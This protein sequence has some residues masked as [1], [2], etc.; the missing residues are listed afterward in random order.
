METFKKISIAVLIVVYVICAVLDFW[1]LY[2]LMFGP[3]KE[4]VNTFH[5]GT[6]TTNP[7]E[8]GETRTEYVIK[9]KYSSNDNKNGLECLDIQFSGFVDERSEEI[10]S[11]GIQFVANS[12]NDSL[13]NWIYNVNKSSLTGTINK[14][15]SFPL[16]WKYYHNIWGSYTP[17]NSSIYYYKSSDSFTRDIT[18]ANSLGNGEGFLI[19]IDKDIYKLNFNY[20]VVNNSPENSNFVAEKLQSSWK[21]FIYRNIT[22]YDYYYSYDIYDFAYMLYQQVQAVSNGKHSASLINLPDMFSYKIFDGKTYK[23]VG[24]DENAKVSETVRNF[25]S[26]Y[27]E[28]T[29]DG[30]KSANDSIFRCVN[31]TPQ[32]NLTD[33][34]DEGGIF[35]DG[36]YL[37]G[38]T[39]VD[40]DM[41]DFDFVNIRDNVCALKLN[42]NFINLYGRYAN[43]IQLSINIDLDELKKKNIVFYG[44]T[45]DS[46]LSKFKILDCYTTQTVDGKIVKTE[47]DYA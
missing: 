16:T 27:I 2:I 34:D 25:Y 6:I 30:V 22:I 45:K 43:N 10:Y 40:C 47:V 15:W 42:K 46:G 12:E 39:I 28:K 17:K 1:W 13:E 24:A 37:I 21:V 29:A 31:G 36:D 4:V 32:F 38:K 14:K 7:D 3:E 41:Y 8:N 20:N 18:G 5:V 9:V 26:I 19:S 44:F 23:D 35:D 33:E 11:W